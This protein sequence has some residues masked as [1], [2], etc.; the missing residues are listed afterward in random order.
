[1]LRRERLPAI[2]GLGYEIIHLRV[3][4]V[5]PV[6]IEADVYVAC[7]CGCRPCEEVSLLI[8][9][10]V[11]VHADDARSGGRE[12]DRGEVDAWRRFAL[13]AAHRICRKRAVSG[14]T[15]DSASRRFRSIVPES[16]VEI[17][18]PVEGEAGDWC[19][20]NHPISADQRGLPH[21]NRREVREVIEEYVRRAAGVDDHVGELCVH[22][23]SA[24]KRWN[25]GRLR[26]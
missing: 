5:A 8:V 24:D 13:P 12:V 22:Q 3:E 14:E 26:R 9:E 7:G 2:G 17:Y 6:V 23:R 21:V 10:N 19:A 18:T 15:M 1:M 4:R 20:R 16:P 25:R 11:V